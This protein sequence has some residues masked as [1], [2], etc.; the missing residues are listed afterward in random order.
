MSHFWRRH[1][2]ELDGLRRLVDLGIPAPSGRGVSKYFKSKALLLSGKSTNGTATYQLH[3][4]V[5]DMA[6]RLL[7]AEPA[8]EGEDSLPGL[9]LTWP[10]AHGQLL[11][12]YRQKTQNGLWHTLPENI[13]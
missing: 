11:E 9:G 12:R 1:R 10:Q 5:H 4:L 7:T 2:W 8:T 13:S 3:D 6:R